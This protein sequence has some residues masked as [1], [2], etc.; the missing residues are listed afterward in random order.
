MWMTEGYTHT[1]KEEL[2]EIRKDDLRDTWRQFDSPGDEIEIQMLKEIEYLTNIEYK[3]L[4]G[5]Y[6]FFS[7]LFN[8]VRMFLTRF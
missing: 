3:G 5:I 6:R 2:I 4:G 8:K 1:T 7:R